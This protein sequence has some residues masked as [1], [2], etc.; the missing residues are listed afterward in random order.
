MFSRLL[1]CRLNNMKGCMC[2]TGLFKFRWSNE[3]KS[4]PSYDHHQIGIIN[5]SHCCHIFLWLCAWSGCTIICCRFHVYSEKAVFLSLFVNSL[6]MCTNNEVHYD[7]MVVFV[8][9]RSTLLHYH[10]FADL[11]ESIEHLKCLSGTFSRECVSK[12]KSILSIIFRAMY[13]LRIFSLPISL[14]MIVRIR[15]LYLIIFINSEVR[16]VCHCLGFGHETTICVVRFFL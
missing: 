10:I 16:P 11:S 2:L 9:L 12:M 8:C 6:M 14:M 3:Y 5:F 15:V 7:P 1:P 13:G 4:F